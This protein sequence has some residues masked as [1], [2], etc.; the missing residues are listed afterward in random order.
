MIDVTMY[1]VYEGLSAH[2]TGKGRFLRGRRG[3]L[4]LGPGHVDIEN[5]GNGL[6]N[7]SESSGTA[8]V[9]ADG[10]LQMGGD[11]PVSAHLLEDRLLTA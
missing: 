4:T 10:D 9:N 3:R 8:E 7:G 1:I 5:T 2:W 11:E 6:P